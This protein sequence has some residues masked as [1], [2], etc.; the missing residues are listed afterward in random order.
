MLNENEAAQLFSCLLIAASR[1]IVCLITGPKF[2]R[3]SSL[4]LGLVIRLL[5]TVLVEKMAWNAL[6]PEIRL[7][8][9]VAVFKTKLLSIIRPPAKPV[10]GIHDPTGLSYLSQI[11]VGLSRLNFHKFKHNFRDTVRPMCPTND[12][13]EDTEH[14]LPLCPSFDVQRRHLLAGV[15]VLLR[16]FVE[17]NSLPNDVLVQI[18]LYGEKNL[19]S[20]INKSIL[21]FTQVF[22]HNTGRFD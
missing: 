11:R 12:G 2:K 20:E 9:S 8:P 17:I 19:S 10:F 16:Q 14:F 3:F 22:I 6:D 7:A 1:F 4:K 13:I 5:Q 21:E 15:S 18:L